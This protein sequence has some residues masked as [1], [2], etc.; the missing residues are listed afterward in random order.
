MPTSDD[1]LAAG[2]AWLQARAPDFEEPT[3]RV[4]TFPELNDSEAREQ[5]ER[6]RAWEA[7]KFEAGYAGIDVPEEFGG[8]GRSTLEAVL[9]AQQEATYRLPLDIFTVSRGM[10][11]PTLLS[12][13]RADQLRDLVPRTM[14]GSLLWCQLFSEPA[15][16]SDLA[17]VRFSASPTSRGW[18]LNGR[19]IWTSYG[20]DADYGY[21]LARTQ[22][23]VVKPHHG[24]T[25]FVV[26]MRSDGIARE[27]IRQATGGASF[28][29]VS[30]DSVAVTADECLGPEGSGWSVA[31][32]TLLWERVSIGPA[33]IPWPHL[34]RR[35]AAVQGDDGA[36]ELFMRLYTA[37]AAV[38][39]LQQRAAIE[40]RSRETPS[41]TGAITKIMA[42]RANE[43]AASWARQ[44]LDD[45]AA[46]WGPWSEYDLGIAGLRL[47][48]GTEDII[49]TM[50]AERLLG[51]PKS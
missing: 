40:M 16:G 1:F 29:E 11:L 38:Q 41:E 36:D 34:L 22:T 20:H 30:F 19:K 3:D 21:V 31:I 32:S 44:T 14:G 48:G 10:V 43:L 45:D 39:L 27:P 18:E 9:F 35:Q 8:L 4:S 13:G 6:A 46:A 2:Q 12:W 15:A 50:L 24:L 37:V 25:A 42:V 7:A 17:A 5:I 47:G 26:D 28:A 33:Q 51:L 49:R 23:D